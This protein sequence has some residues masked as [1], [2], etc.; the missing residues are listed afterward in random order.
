MS[1]Y[2]KAIGRTLAIV[3]ALLLTMQAGEAQ[4]P[5]HLMV[6]PEINDFKFSGDADAT[7][8][9]REKDEDTNEDFQAEQYDFR[10][11]VPVY[12]TPESEW[13]LS[14]QV[15]AWELDTSARFDESGWKVPDQLADV[16]FG[17][18][19][20]QVINDG[21]VFSQNLQFGSASDKPFDSIEE[22]WVGGTS[23]LRIPD[24]E[25]N[26]RLLMLNFQTGREIPVFPAVAYQIV[27]H[28]TLAAVVGLPV[29]AIRYWPADWLELDALA[30]PPGDLDAT[31][32]LKPSSCL[33][34]WVGFDWTRSSFL[35]ADRD[36]WNDRIDIVQKRAKAGAE[37]ALSEELTL[38][39]GGGYAFDRMVGEGKNWDERNDNDIDVEDGWYGTAQVCWRF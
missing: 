25:Y 1:A 10:L 13:L 19:Y 2:Y 35:R 31:L 20:R 14:T 27:L 8:Y 30:A 5:L 22:T 6:N 38:K 3:L 4:S 16:R 36:A 12:R 33:K 34:A 26:A 32:T 11:H 17:V 39:A 37:L 28:R 18:T 29:L 23:L 7:Y 15:E 24:G 21:W 9:D